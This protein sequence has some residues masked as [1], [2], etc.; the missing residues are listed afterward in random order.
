MPSW[1][2]D[3]VERAD[4]RMVQRGDRA[5][6]TLESLARI[7]SVATCAR[8]DLDRDGPAKTRVARPVHFA[9]AARA[10]AR[11]DLV[12]ADGT[13]FKKPGGGQRV[14]HLRS[15]LFEKVVRGLVGRQQAL[16]FAAQLLV[17]ATR[18]V[19]IAGAEILRQRARRVEHVLHALPC[20][21]IGAHGEVAAILANDAFWCV[22]TW[23][24]RRV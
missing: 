6:L 21:A 11:A 5:R 10:D 8:Q 16:D 1:R 12:R 23:G 13:A 22:F 15:R 24:L 4:M 7:G 3:V 17:G 19:E 20:T 2:A 9:H 18:V 14:E